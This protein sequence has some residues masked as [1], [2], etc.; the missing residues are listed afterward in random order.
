MACSTS[1]TP[2]TSGI[3]RPRATTA[4]VFD[5]ASLTKV[6]ATASNNHLGTERAEQWLAAAQALVELYADH[7]AVSFADLAA[8]VATEVR[9]LR[10]VE[11]ERA[12][13][14]AERER[15]YRWV[16]MGGLA[17]SVPGLA[18]VGGPAV[19]ACMGDPGRFA[20]GKQFRSFTGLAPRAS[21][22]G[23]SD[24]KGQPMS[25]AGSSLLRATFVRAADTARKQD[26]QLARIYHA[27][28]VERGKDHLGALCVV[29]ANLERRYEPRAAGH[30]GHPHRPAPLI[31]ESVIPQMV[32]GVGDQDDEHETSPQGLHILARARAMRPS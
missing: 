2:A 10:A 9:L 18:E 27:Q 15:C 19:A 16:D 29:A 30:G 7:P 3:F 6:I 24:R 14:A 28:M 1:F 5:L 20:A 8:E 21:E 22:T 4:T 11:A 23:E 32:V 25:K 31:K 17:R 26:P 12:L 13:H